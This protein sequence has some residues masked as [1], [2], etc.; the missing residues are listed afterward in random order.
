MSHKKD[1][2]P[3]NWQAV[4]D[5]PD[6]ETEES[7]DINVDESVDESVDENAD[8][9]EKGKEKKA[10]T[11]THNKLQEMISTLQMQL[12]EAESKADENW[13]L[14]LRT[15]ADAENVRARAEREI[16]K[17]HKYAPERVISEILQIVD[18]LEQGLDASD[19][20]DT[21]VKTIR[22]GIELTLKMFLSVLEKFSVKQMNPLGESFDSNFHEAISMQATA[23]AEPGTV[24]MVM[25][26][27]YLI[28]DR[29]LRSAKVIVAKEST[30]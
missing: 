16:A 22:H 12:E 8:K 20:E 10:K 13:D 4:I 28:H 15:R 2:Q 29:V 26:K 27:G 23:D 9:K 11:E 24:V 7:V 1:E 3:K 21:D 5:A 25:Q 18:S 19:A 6:E 30:Q 17:A 14:L